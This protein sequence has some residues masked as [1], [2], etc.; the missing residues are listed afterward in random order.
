MEI[1]IETKFLD[2]LKFVFEEKKYVL[3]VVSLALGIGFFYAL[4][5]NLIYV[6]PTFFI[7]YYRLFDDGFIN[8]VT[9]ILFLLAVPILASLTITLFVYK[10]NQFRRLK[11]SYKEAGMGGVGMFAALFTSTCSECVPLFL[12]AAGVSYGLFAATLS[13]FVIWSRVLAILILG[14]SFY[15]ASKEVTNLCKIKISPKMK[16]GGE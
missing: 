16:R 14:I 2:G 8:L 9:G 1:N 4:S 7:N 15:Y 5:I 10:L 3:L 11:K 12:Y 13:P 6:Q